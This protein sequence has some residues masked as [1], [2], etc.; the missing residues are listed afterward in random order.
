V[1][2]IPDHLII[3]YRPGEEWRTVTLGESEGWEDLV[4]ELKQECFDL[5]EQ[6]KAEIYEKQALEEELNR[7]REEQN[8]CK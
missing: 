4:K 2:H 3:E 6:V 1:T 8:P 7:A 5:R